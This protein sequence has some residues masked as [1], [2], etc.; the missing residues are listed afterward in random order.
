MVYGLWLLLSSNTI[1]FIIINVTLYERH[2]QLQ[3][4]DIK[5]DEQ[6]SKILDAASG[7]FFFPISLSPP[8][9]NSVLRLSPSSDLDSVP[10]PPQLCPHSLGSQTAANVSLW[11]YNIKNS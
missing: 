9:H 1:L 5:S 10:P 6:Q 7:G 11:H 4:P 2:L 3:P 8:S